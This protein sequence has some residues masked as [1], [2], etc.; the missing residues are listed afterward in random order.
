MSELHWD[1]P[2]KPAELAENRLVS[3]I[4]DGTFPIDSNLPPKGTAARLG[5]PPRRAKGY[6]PFAG[7]CWKST[8][9]RHPRAN[10]GRR[11]PQPAG[12]LAPTGTSTPNFLPT[13]SRARLMAPLHTPVDE[14][15][16][17]EGTPARVASAPAG[18]PRCLCRTRFPP[19]FPPCVLSAIPF[20]NRY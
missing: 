2:E 3:A 14:R 19:A 4:L 16:L 12:A 9:A 8:T 5:V 1:A 17:T 11:A 18:Y 15:S 20:F 13:C 7:W 10:F 6:T